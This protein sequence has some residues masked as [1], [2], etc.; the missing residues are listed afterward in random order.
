MQTIYLITAGGTM[1]TM[2]SEHSG[3][4]FGCD[5]KI[6]RYLSQ[7]RLPDCDM[8]VVP[9]MDKDSLEI[10]LEDRRRLAFEVAKLLGEEHP[11]VITHDTDTMIDTGLYILREFVD[12]EGPVIL[13][14]AMTPPGFEG[15]DGLQNLTESLL[16]AQLLGPGVFIVMHGQVFPGD[17]V[18]KDTQRK[19]FVRVDRG[20]DN[21]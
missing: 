3:E 17:R 1:E 15:S 7:L 19:I 9:L 16:A 2:H 10:T 11:I 5:G 14:G 6:E 12:L 8:R 21:Q 4:V 13:T 20:D 18:R